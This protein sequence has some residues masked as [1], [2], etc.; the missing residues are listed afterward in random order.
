MVPA[1]SA[2]EQSARLAALRELS[3]FTPATAE[4]VLAVE[5]TGAGA[6]VV[7]ERL[8]ALPVR[9]RRELVGSQ[10]QEG[11]SGSPYGRFFEVGAGFLKARYTRRYPNL[12]AAQV[13]DG[14]TE[15]LRQELGIYHP[16][17]LWFVSR[18]PDGWCWACSWTPTLPLLRQRFATRADRGAWDL[19]LQAIRGTLELG[20]A[21]GLWLDC[22]PNNYGIASDG[23]VYLDD[24]LAISGQ[25]A[26]VGLQALLRLREYSSAAME[27]RQAFLAGFAELAL[28]LGRA[29]AV[30]ASLLEDISQ[31]L[32]WPREPELREQL[33]AFAR[34]LASTRDGSPRRRH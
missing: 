27:D 25:R 23:V 28:E 1:P 3:G 5:P 14:A 22:N 30:R 33:S 34:R 6:G 15:R 4:D 31:Q 8:A 10:N 12:A 2:A 17:R 16:Q 19:Y 18:D 26:T 32:L 24:D 20:V 29:P 7:L 9:E 11:G 13:A 21:R